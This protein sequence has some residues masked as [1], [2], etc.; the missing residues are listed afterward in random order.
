MGSERAGRLAGHLVEQRAVHLVGR[1]AVHLVFLKADLGGYWV[2]QMVEQK[3]LN[4]ADHWVVLK[5]EQ[6]A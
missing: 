4:W 1:M 2:G 3:V 5:V 6:R